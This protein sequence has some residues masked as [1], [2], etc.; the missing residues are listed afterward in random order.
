MSDEPGDGDIFAPVPKPDELLALSDITAEMFAILRSW[1]DVPP[2][3]TLDLVEVDSAVSELADP[4]MIAALAMRK[5]QALNLLATPGVRT[6]TDVV[7]TI[8]SDLD[9]ALVQAPVMRLR[10]AAAA[11]DWDAELAW[12]EGEEAA[13]D[14]APVEATDAD[15]EAAHF[16]ALHA[17]LHAAMEAVVEAT[18]GEIRILE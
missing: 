6:T 18:G 4:V 11:T 12:L 1:F 7:V 16:R 2:R 15:P 10:L 3:V 8:V 13:V 9:R 17:K 5:L 14:D